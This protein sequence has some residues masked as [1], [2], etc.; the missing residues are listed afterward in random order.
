MLGKPLGGLPIVVFLDAEVDT[1]GNLL[2][3]DGDGH[4]AAH[5]YVHGQNTAHMDHSV[6]RGKME[7]SQLCKTMQREYYLVTCKRTSPPVTGQVS[8]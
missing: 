5:G 8:L 3:T 7:I 6:G 4:L 1:D 2:H